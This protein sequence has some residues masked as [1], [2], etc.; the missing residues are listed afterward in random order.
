MATKL[1]LHNATTTVGG[2]LPGASSQSATA[3][4]VTA[5]GA[6]TNRVMDTTIGAA[7]TS[8]AL[9]TLASTAQQRNWFRRFISPPLSAQTVGDV[10]GITTAGAGSVSNTNSNAFA[11]YGMVAVWRPSTGALVG[12]VQDVVASN[13]FSVNVA[14]ETAG[15]G[16][17]SVG[18]TAI[19]AL[20]GDVLI[21]EMWFVN[22]QGMG[23]AYTNTFFYDGTTEASATSN[24]AYIEL[25][26]T[27]IFQPPPS[28][29]AP[30][31]VIAPSLAAQLRS[32]W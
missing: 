3:P 16:F 1:Y 29:G 18:Q 21:F 22:T 28:A 14:A 32:R 24:A 11:A 2:I 10:A 30:K 31:P 4:S 9:T 12:R 26:D 27:L 19:A 8:A 17:L 7:Q 13:A 20:A 6:S 23:T 5:A 15:N 25:N